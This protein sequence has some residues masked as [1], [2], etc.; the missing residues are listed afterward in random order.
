[1][2]YTLA[3]GRSTSSSICS[4]RHTQAALFETRFFDK[5]DVQAVAK[6]VFVVLLQDQG[7][8]LLPE[9]H[10]LIGLDDEAQ[11]I[12]STATTPFAWFPR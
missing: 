9:L 12:D 2:E 5:V 8:S 3:T 7:C 11:F 1:M 4:L 10:K 6:F